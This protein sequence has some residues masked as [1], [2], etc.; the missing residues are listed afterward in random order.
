MHTTEPLVL[1]PSC[2]KVV[3]IGKLKRYKLLGVDYIL[4]E[5]IQAGGNALYSKIHKLFNLSRLTGP[6]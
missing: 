5:L 1:E 2:F 3:T 6:S 4:A